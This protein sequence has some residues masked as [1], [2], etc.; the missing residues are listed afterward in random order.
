VDLDGAFS[1]VPKNLASVKK[2]IRAVDIP[3]EFGGGVRDKGTAEKIFALGAKRIVLGTK[4]IEDQ[5]FLKDML[6]E[7]QDKIIVS[8]DAKNG[9]VLTEGWQSAKTDLKAVEF[10]L[11]LEDLGFGEIIYTD[12][13]LDGTLKGPN[14]RS[15]EEL[16]KGTGLKIIASGGISSLEDL[17]KLKELNR[18]RIS[19]VIVG[20]A[21]YENR[22]TL[23]EAIGLLKN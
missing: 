11:R 13:S 21:L 23:K 1:G 18:K 20:K 5:D 14:L 16:L 15:I 3:V 8:I 7:Y 6:R 10:A 22:F 2:I 17:K 12:T 9:S 4:A 19:G